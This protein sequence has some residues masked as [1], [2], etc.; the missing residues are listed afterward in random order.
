MMER[1][2]FWLAATVVAFA[3][4]TQSEVLEVAENHA[5]SFDPFVGKAT[6]AATEIV[7]PSTGSG[8]KLTNFYVFG[9]YGASSGSTYDNV[10]YTNAS[11]TVSSSSYTNVGPTG[12]TQYWVPD[13]KY[14]FAAYSDGNN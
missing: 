13:M 4:C 5:I 8:T 1:S 7:D 10:V 11:V 3:S 14:M 12:N 2:I 9:R 6:R